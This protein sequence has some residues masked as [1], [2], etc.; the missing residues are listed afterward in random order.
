MAASKN[1]LSSLQCNAKSMPKFPSSQAISPIMKKELNENR[2]C[3]PEE[4]IQ[5]EHNPNDFSRLDPSARIVN[6]N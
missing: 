3:R 6:H 5:D 1:R 2:K 4:D